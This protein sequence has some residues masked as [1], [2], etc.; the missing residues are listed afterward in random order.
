MYRKQLKRSYSMT[1]NSQM[2]STKSIP[3]FSSG[4]S[5]DGALTV[6]HK[7]Y[8]CDI[9]GSADFVIQN[10]LINPGNSTLFPWL[11]Q[12]AQNYDEYTFHGLIFHFRSTSTDQ[13]SN[14]SQLGTLIMAANYNPSAPNFVN[15]QQ[16]MEYS[17]ASSVKISNDLQFG[18][19]CDPKK[20]GGNTIEYV[21]PNGAAPIGEDAKTYHL[22]N[23]QIATNSTQTVNQIGELWCTYKVTLRKPKYCVTNA[24]CQP[25]LQAY[26][27]P[28][29]VFPGSTGET[30]TPFLNLTSKLTLT[31]SLGAPSL[32]GYTTNITGGNSTP[33][34]SLNG[35]VYGIGF[36]F[37]DTLGSGT[38]NIQLVWT[39]ESSE[40]G[41]GGLAF[42]KS[43]NTTIYGDVLSTDTTSTGQSARVITW[44]AKITINKSA[45]AAGLSGTS[46]SNGVY[47]TTPSGTYFTC[48]FNNTSVTWAASNTCSLLINQLNPSVTF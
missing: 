19:E 10:H 40:F 30:N 28:G 46:T 2:G 12:I 48:G 42:H 36:R 32:N 11:A 9:Q 4:R 29:A 16:M 41:S 13:A 22:A 21:A 18:I 3:S 15:K 27:S 43:T 33:F 6:S 24:L 17:G 5:E 8:I 47:V 23:L 44:S 26:N 25:Y 38:Y 37:P 45:F 20:R 1:K 14:N 31:T 34:N 39:T 35:T 7:E